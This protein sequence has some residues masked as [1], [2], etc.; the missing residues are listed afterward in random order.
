MMNKNAFK[1]NIEEKKENKTKEPVFKLQEESEIKYL[2]KESLKKLSD[3]SDKKYQKA[4]EELA[5]WQST[6]Q[7]RI[8]S[9]FI[10]LL[11]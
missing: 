11:L 6:F 1:T 2:D 8:S 7:K 5:K 4:Y 9:I 10:Q 3:I